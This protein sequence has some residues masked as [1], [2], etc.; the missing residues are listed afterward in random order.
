MLKNWT[1]TTQAVKNATAGVMIREK[2]LLSKSHPNHKNTERILNL[3][4]NQ[5]TS[6][7]IAIAGEHFRTTQ[8]LNNKGGRPLQSYAMEFCLTMP[9]GYRPT[10]EQWRSIVRDICIT[11]A[12]KLE[13]TDVEFEHFKTRLRAVVHQ[14]KQQGLGAGDHVHLIMPK[15]VGARILKELQRKQVTRLIKQSFNSAVLEHTGYDY[16]QYVP[17]A[18]GRGKRLDEWQYQQQ[19][20]KRAL[21]IQRLVTKLQNQSD[22]W[23]KAFSKNDEKQLNRQ[24]NRLI[25]TFEEL[26]SLS[27]DEVTS[28]NISLLKKDIQKKSNRDII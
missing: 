11:V 27:P 16:T 13:L 21:K 8:M 3:L 19:E 15:I 23:F 4:G 2:Y 25:K 17:K 28:K 9:Q 12:K 24:F 20:A 5:K 1:V 7:R 18:T 26:A 6:Q 14:Q 22:K 10:P